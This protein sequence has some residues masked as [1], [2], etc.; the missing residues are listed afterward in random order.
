MWL[1]LKNTE[2]C[3]I[4]S[5]LWQW[6]SGLN[7]NSIDDAEHLASRIEAAG[8]GDIMYVAIILVDEEG[9]DIDG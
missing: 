8:E 6:S 4:V 9:S 7:I 1:K 5:A 2:R 3:Y